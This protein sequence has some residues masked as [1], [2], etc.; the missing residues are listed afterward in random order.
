M[1]LGDLGGFNPSL[2]TSSAVAFFSGILEGQDGLPAP[3]LFPVC[4]TQTP[5]RAGRH[6]QPHVA[7]LDA[8]PCQ[9]TTGSAWF[10]HPSLPQSRVLGQFLLSAG[11][12]FMGS[13]QAGCVRKDEAPVAEERKIPLAP[14]VP[15]PVPP[16]PLLQF[17]GI[18]DVACATPWD[19][20][21]PTE[22]APGTREKP[23]L[24][25]AIGKVPC[26][27]ELLIPGHGDSGSCVLTGTFDLGAV[28]AF[29]APGTALLGCRMVAVLPTFDRAGFWGHLPSCHSCCQLHRPGFGYWT[30]TFGTFLGYWGPL[31]DVGDSV[32]PGNGKGQTSPLAV[33]SRG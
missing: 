17:G 7:A 27:W 13:V 30:G 31:K 29:V 21:V 11:K 1:D 22:S 9:D 28:P 20:A 5:R 12:D 2:P 3:Q 19:V 14:S 25:A 23:P 26:V 4:L 16:V 10:C 15:C 18:R 33:V 6:L 8:A 32:A 24:S